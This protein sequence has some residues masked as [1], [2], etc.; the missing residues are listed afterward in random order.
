[1]EH[2]LDA[3]GRG[4]HGL[5]TGHQ[6]LERYT[7]KELERLIR[8]RQ[9]EPMRP[10]VYR[11]AGTPPTWEQRVLAT[12]LSVAPPAVASH[13]TAAR[14]WGISYVPAV[15]VEI[16]IPLGHR[17]RLPG[18]RAHEAK[19]PPVSVFVSGI[20]VTSAARTLVD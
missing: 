2:P 11:L 5:V 1:M 4:Q 15:K 14:L 9:L 7:P 10:G 13:R 8:I 20:P 12:C 17:V 6:V 18:V 19:V 16:T 3:F